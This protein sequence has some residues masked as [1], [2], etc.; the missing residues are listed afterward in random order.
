MK[1]DH[2]LHGKN[3]FVFWIRQPR[4]TTKYTKCTKG[5]V[6]WLNAPKAEEPDSI[7][8]PAGTGK[9]GDRQGRKKSPDEMEKWRYI[10]LDFAG[11]APFIR[12]GA[13]RAIVV[14]SPGHLG[15]VLHVVPMLKAL[16]SAKPKIKIIWLVGPWSEALARRFDEISAEIRVF[17][18]NLPNF[19]R[20][21]PNFRQNAWF[22]WKFALELRKI[23]VETLIG[24]LDGVGRFLANAICPK[25]WI[26]MGDRRPPRVLREIQTI[27]QPYEKDRYEAD[28]WCGLLKPLGIEE[29]ADRLEYEVKPGENAAAEAY[30]RAEGVDL[31]CPLVLIAPGSG[32]SGKNWLPERFAE[33]AEWLKA[34]KGVQIAWVGAPGEE[35]LVPEAQKG[36]LNWVGRTTIPLLAAI[37]AKSQLFIGNDAGLLH[38]AAAV[39]LPTVSIWGPTS[40]GKW[41]PKGPIHR[42]IRK[43]ERCE[44]C[45][46]WDYREKCRHDHACMKAVTVED[47]KLQIIQLF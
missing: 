13:G 37:M 44:G 46:Y 31:G 30:L 28:A 18:P 41:G 20:K 10:L 16:R 6:R 47:V 8:L 42:Q 23:G 34:E 14:F 32:W 12:R 21:N 43:V 33:V 26:G 3:G 27:A 39:G 36:D 4:V 9:I 7:L 15:D 40:P 45:I 5:R 1:S 2:G 11:R 38:F 24:P 17:G 25:L 22:Q 19:T 35:N 29:T